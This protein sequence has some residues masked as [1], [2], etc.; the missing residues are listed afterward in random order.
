MSGVLAVLPAAALYA[1][2]VVRAGRRLPWW[3]AACGTAALALCGLALGPLDARVD[4]TL[5]GHMVQHVILGTLAPALLAI[6][7]PMRLALA[8]LP[9]RGRRALASVM[10]APAMR[11]LLRPPVALGLAGAVLLIGHLPL[12][13]AAVA[14]NDLWHGVDHAL[15]FWTATLAWVSLLGADPVRDA[16]GPVGLMAGVAAWMLPMAAVGAVYAGAD[17]VLVA[18]Y[19]TSPSALA[20]EHAAGTIMLLVGPALMGPIALV[21]AGRKLWAEEDRQRRRERA[22]AAR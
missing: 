20:D 1:G 4:R 11:L 18:A 3:R 15:L 7:A 6:A 17:H 14:Q 9:G 2:G 5:S 22:E 13:L 19:A 16:P 10:H 12:A 21:A 8:S